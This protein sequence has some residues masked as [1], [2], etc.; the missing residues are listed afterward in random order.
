M[1]REVELSIS[2]LQWG[3]D[4]D[5]DNIE[6]VVKAEYFKK[7]DSHYLLYEETMEGFSQTSKNRMKFKNNILEMTRQGLMNTHMVFEE[8]KKHV[9]NY[10]T[11]YGSLLLGI[12]TK[13]FCVEEK[14]DC[15]QVMVDY[16]LETEGEILSQNKI[17]I[18]IRE[19]Q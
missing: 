5:Q 2:G 16:V 1:N 12:D 3:T 7:N 8:N 19:R 4:T 18:R 17:E 6:T 13:K 10:V 14:D 15:I 9:T 11:P